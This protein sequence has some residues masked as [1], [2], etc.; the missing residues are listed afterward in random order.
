MCRFVCPTAIA[1]AR[2]TVTPTGKQT[3]L[4][5]VQRGAAPLDTE[6]A[7]VFY[8]CTG[9]GLCTQYCE[10]EIQVFPVMQAAR[11][12]AV[13]VGVSSGEALR[14]RDNYRQFGNPYGNLYPAYANKASSRIVKGAK[15]YYVPGSS[16]SEADWTAIDAAFAV[17][18][19]L[20]VDNVA[21]W[22]GPQLDSGY[23]L[24]ALGFQEDFRH[25]AAAF[26]EVANGAERLIFASP[27][28]AET[29]I[30]LYPGVGVQIRAQVLTEPEFLAP[31]VE[32]LSVPVQTPKRVLYHDPCVLGRGLG[33]YDAPRL[34]IAKLNRA[35]PLEFAWHREESK[36]CGWGGGYAFT[37]SESARTV[38]RL[39]REEASEQQPDE[40]V[41]A[42]TAC[43]VHLRQGGGGVPV[44]GFMEWLAARLR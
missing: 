25:H 13:E 37:V 30:K 5:L 11:T 28:D 21:F 16:A 7:A 15:V 2:E 29:I 14:V 36:C 8:Q 3:L 35:E 31:L 44:Y 12:A 9:C 24:H 39:R 27:H 6:T 32:K 23:V 17:F 20:G 42:S 1:E 26:A 18:D 43:A 22:P 40:I 10:H 19:A 34:L 33:Q 41:T 4:Y 38:A